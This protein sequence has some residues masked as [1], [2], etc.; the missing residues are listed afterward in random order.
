MNI[1]KNMLLLITV[2][3]LGSLVLWFINRASGTAALFQL[4]WV[5]F[6]LSPILVVIGIILIV[7]KRTADWTIAFISVAGIVLVTGIVLTTVFQ[8]K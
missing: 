7:A 1:V 2:I 6:F 5:Y 4:G 3:L 8:I